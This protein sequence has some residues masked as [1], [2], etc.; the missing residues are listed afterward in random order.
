[1]NLTLNFKH[2]SL[3]CGTQ[4]KIIMIWTLVCISISH[5]HGNRLCSLHD[6]GHCSALLDWSALLTYSCSSLDTGPSSA[7]LDILLLTQALAQPLLDTDDP[8]SALL[9]Y[10]CSALLKYYCSALLKYHCSALH[11]GHRPL[12]NPAGH[13]PL[14]TQPCWTQALAQPCWTQA[15]AHATLLDTGPCPRSHAGHR[16]LLSHAGHRPLLSHAGHRP[17]LSHAGHRPLLSSANF[18]P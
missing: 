15:L 14:P 6:T 9:K 4:E 8:C 11:A 1:M 18:K 16:P 10:Y 3:K 2:D 7:L 5:T 13:R 17:L 12:P